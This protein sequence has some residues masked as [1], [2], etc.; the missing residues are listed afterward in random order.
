M[1]E[2]RQTA[3]PDLIDYLYGLPALNLLH[4]LPVAVLAI[5]LTGDVVYANQACADMLGYPDGS[6][7][8]REPLPVLLAH[9]EEASPTECL[10]ELQSN[11]TSVAWHHTEHY[12]VQTRVSTPLLV[13]STDPVLLISITDLTEWIWG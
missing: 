1:Q 11:P 3:P 10:A 4:R 7:V 12:A 2:R 9:R 5:A 13:R 8:V 6:A